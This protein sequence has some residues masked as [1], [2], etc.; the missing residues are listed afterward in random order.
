MDI[1][2]VI[3]AL[4]LKTSSSW[5]NGGIERKHGAI[6]LTIRKMMED[7]QELKLEDA[8]QYATWS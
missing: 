5:S 1:S 8:F 7:D 3:T 4:N 2:S 6:D